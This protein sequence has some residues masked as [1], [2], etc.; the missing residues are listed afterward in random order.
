VKTTAH[1]NLVL[2]LRIWYMSH[3]YSFIMQ[4]LSTGTTRDPWRR[5]RDLKV[6]SET[7]ATGD[8][9]LHARSWPLR[10]AHFSILYQPQRVF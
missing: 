6:R 3:K 9:W 7:K 2:M 4:C 5:L 10:S 8:K 1:L